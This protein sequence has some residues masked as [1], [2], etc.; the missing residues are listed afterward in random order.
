MVT[1]LVRVDVAV[2]VR[3]LPLHHRDVGP[4]R[5]GRVVALYDGSREVRGLEGKHIGAAIGAAVCRGAG[6]CLARGNRVARDG[7]GETGTCEVGGSPTR[8]GPD[9]V[10]A[11][12]Q[13]E[14]DKAGGAA[15]APTRPSGPL[16]VIK[17]GGQAAV[18]LVPTLHVESAVDLSGLVGRVVDDRLEVRRPPGHD[19]RTTGHRATAGSVVGVTGHRAV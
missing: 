16:R 8:S 6:S 3:V 14:F 5:G 11:V 2:V 9:V 1:A 18:G 4:R 17:I 7:D 15:V 13:R 19:H 12:G 10:E